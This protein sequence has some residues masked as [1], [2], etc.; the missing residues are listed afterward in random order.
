MFDERTSHIEQRIVAGTW[1]FCTAQFKGPSRE[2]A[3]MSEMI[4]FGIAIGIALLMY[5]RLMT[6]LPKRRV[7]NGPCVDRSGSVGGADVGDGGGHFVWGPGEDSA[8]DHSVAASDS[9]GGDGGG[10]GDA[11]GG[12]DGGS[13]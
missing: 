4:A 11:G 6:R 13:G 9:G 8:S 5:H 2:E 1:R 3:M 10:G 7:I 12:G